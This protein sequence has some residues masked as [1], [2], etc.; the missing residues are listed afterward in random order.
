L[1]DLD[2]ALQ[3]PEFHP[4]APSFP[5]TDRLSLETRLNNCVSPI[6]GFS[7][8]RVIFID[9]Y[10]ISVIE[11]PE[12]KDN[13]WPYG[14]STVGARRFTPPVKPDPWTGIRTAEAATSIRPEIRIPASAQ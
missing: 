10:T 2:L 12:G 14:A 13:K 1:R 4:I 8:P 5:R 3:V 11:K 9:R 6:L 7:G